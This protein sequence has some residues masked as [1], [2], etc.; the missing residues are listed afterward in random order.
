[1]LKFKCDILSDFQTMWKWS[2]FIWILMFLRK[3]FR[4]TTLMIFQ[5]DF[6]TKNRHS[7]IGR[8]PHCLWQWLSDFFLS[9]FFNHRTN[10]ATVVEL[11]VTQ[12]SIVAKSGQAPK[13]LNGFQCIFSSMNSKCF[14]MSHCIICQN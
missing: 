5:V 10:V 13:D 9:W 11:L 4:L 7:Y 12:F 6:G 3:Y 2:N 1:M 8:M 14:G